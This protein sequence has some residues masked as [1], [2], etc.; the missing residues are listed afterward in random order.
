[1]LDTQPAQVEA[2]R[3]P[4]LPCPDHGALEHGRILAVDG[5]DARQTWLAAVETANRVAPARDGW[6]VAL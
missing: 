3:E 2:G 5:Y 4:G 1:V 6:T